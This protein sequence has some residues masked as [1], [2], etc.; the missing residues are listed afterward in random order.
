M[1]DYGHLLHFEKIYPSTLTVWRQ[2]MEWCMQVTAWCGLYDLLYSHSEIL[3]LLIKF[4]CIKM[5]LKE[6][7]SKVIDQI[8]GQDKG[9]G[10]LLWT[11]Q[12][13]FKF[14]RRQEVAYLGDI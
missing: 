4:N 12:G 6:M 7:G 2:V 14:H 5:C 8:L 1:F 9:S 3:C 10:G 11:R 13:L